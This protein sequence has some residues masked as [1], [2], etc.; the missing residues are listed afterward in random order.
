MHQERTEGIVLLSLDYKENQ[1]IITI[2]SQDAGVMSLI[3]KNPSKRNCRQLTLSSPF[4]QAEFIYRKGRSE[5]CT[6]IDGHP[7]N[8]NLHLRSQLSF[9]QTAGLLTKAILT[10]QLPGKAAPDLY[11]LFTLYFKQITTFDDPSILISSF[12]LKLLKHE[13][14]TEISSLCSTCLHYPANTLYEGE[15]YCEHHR[16][17][18]ALSHP[19]EE[20]TLLQSLSHA[21]SFQQLYAL[22]PSKKLT[23]LIADTFHS[24]FR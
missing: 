9:V 15:S 3:L 10:S 6:F 8:E 1:K 7:I 5:L 12:Y 11:R 18:H 13:G 21:K 22:K 2:F 20:W 17:S 24:K 19:P 23:A 14:L 16:P 4:C